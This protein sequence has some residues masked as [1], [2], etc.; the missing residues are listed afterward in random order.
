[1]VLFF[2]FERNDNFYFFL[3]A[4]VGERIKD[5]LFIRTLATAI[6][7]NSI[8]KNKLNAD[9]L[10]GHYNLI[11]RFVDNKAEY[12]LQCLFALQALINKLEHPQGKLK[13]NTGRK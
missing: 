4:N 1:M 13:T 10:K 7:E 3:K 9:V 6:F 11:H 5:K 8:V 2:N 12:E